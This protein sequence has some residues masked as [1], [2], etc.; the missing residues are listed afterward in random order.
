AFRKR[1][2]RRC[3]IC[4]K[5]QRVDVRRGM[6]W[7][8]GSIAKRASTT[9]RAVRAYKSRVALQRRVRNSS[10]PPLR[11]RTRSDRSS[12][13][14]GSLRSIPPR[15]SVPMQTGRTLGSGLFLSVSPEPETLTQSQ[16]PRKTRNQAIT[17]RFDVFAEAKVVRG[18][19]PSPCAEA[20]K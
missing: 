8:H 5:I 7:V 17:P 19:I 16:Q 3:L 4:V 20:H 12:P 15:W 14:F 13:R 9:N 6:H 18:V 2:R 1:S 10:P 11:F